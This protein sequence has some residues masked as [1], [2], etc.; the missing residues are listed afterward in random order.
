MSDATHGPLANTLKVIAKVEPAEIK[1]VVLSFIY[2]F[3]LMTS[4][5]ILRPL[6]DTMGTVYGVAHLQE[7]FTGNLPALG[8]RLHCP[9]H[10]DLLCAVPKS[11]ERP[12][13][14]RQLLCLDQHVQLAHDFGVLEPDG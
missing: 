2:F 4:Y 8:L 14:G 7:L 11:S 13:G 6:R 10:A 9:H 12:L 1:A 5:F 3:F